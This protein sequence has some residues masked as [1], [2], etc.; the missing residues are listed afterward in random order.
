MQRDGNHQIE[1]GALVMAAESKWVI[2]RCAADATSASLRKADTTSGPRRDRDAPDRKFI[3][4][5]LPVSFNLLTFN[6][7]DYV[8][9]ESLAM[10]HFRHGCEAVT[11]TLPNDRTSQRV[12]RLYR[13]PVA[14][15]HSIALARWHLL[16]QQ[17]PEGYW[18]GELEGD[19]IL[20]SETILILAFFEREGS[21]LVARLAR[22]LLETQTSDGAWSLYPG[23]PI[24]ISASVKAYFAL[25]LAGYSPSDPALR[26]A[27]NVILEHGGA[28]A[29]NSFTRFY[30]AFLGQIPYRICPAVPPEVLLLPGWF[31]INLYKMSAWS[32]AMVVPLSVLWALKPV[33]ELPPEKGIRELFLTRPEDWPLTRGSGA[34]GARDFWSAF[35]Q[36]TDAC[37]KFAERWGLVPFRKRALRA[38]EAWIIEHMKDSHGLAAIYPPMVWS[39]IALHAMGYSNDSPIMREAWQRV[40]EL[41]LENEAQETARIQPC[42]SPVW[43]TA[44]SLRA[45]LSAGARPDDVRVQKAVAWL[46]DHQVLRPGDWSHTVKVHPGGWCFEHA[47]PFYPDCDD[48]AAAL[49]ALAG[50]FDDQGEQTPDLFGPQWRIVRDPGNQSPSKL[51][52]GRKKALSRQELESLAE[53]TNMAIH[54]G[55]TWL[56]GMQS[57]NGGWAAFDRDNCCAVLTKVP[58]A[59]H[60]AMID[61]STPDITGRVLEALGTLGYRQGF[62][63]VDRAVAYLRRTQE[64]DGSWFGRWGV[65]YIY[66]TWLAIS[67]LRAVGISED[68]PA[69]VAGVNWLISHQLPDGGWGESPAT[70]DHPHLRG[71]G[72]STASQTAWAILG[73][74]AGG[75]NDHPAVLRGVRYLLEH[76]SAD[77][78]WKEAAFTGTGFPRVFYLRYHMYPL[79]FPLLALSRF[80]RLNAGRLAELDLPELRVITPPVD[81]EDC[82]SRIA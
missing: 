24:D 42:L 20:Q 32:R 66:G 6:V 14:I 33:R 22:R 54:R 41:L 73:L 62:P 45:V 44:L 60:N 53:R 57:R 59:D 64:A 75:K 27:A 76:Q 56:L 23:G 72:L 79:Y 12:E 77:G 34:R 17:H 38:A 21:P 3:L 82:T 63:A 7:S 30:L 4:P 5:S 67:G 29:V 26:R 50:Q 65:N 1:G 35:F 39:L 8:T 74:L 47:N 52:D 40:E 61:P 31:P 70:Y 36:T 43:D 9:E 51:H 46:L 15:R 78:S 18:Q 2:Q 16:N 58:F 11:E 10:E 71:S 28:Q 19:S 55:V 48:T 25:K 68:D 81:V 13:L 69:V 80:V 37:L 49:I